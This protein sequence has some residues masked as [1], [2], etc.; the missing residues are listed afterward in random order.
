MVKISDVFIGTKQSRYAAFAIFSA[1]MAVCLFI[2]FTSTDVPFGQRFGIV[3]FLIIFSIPSVLMTLF[4]LTCIVTGGTSKKN[5]WCHYFAWIIALIII[6]YSIIIIIS[7]IMSLFTYNNAMDRVVESENAKRLTKEEAN[8]YA[9]NMMKHE[10]SQTP[11]NEQPTAQS[12]TQPM[13]QP[14][15]QPMSQHMSQP[16]AQPMSQPM[17]QPMT[18]SNIPPQNNMMTEKLS[19]YNGYE[20]TNNNASYLSGAYNNP[21]SQW[22]TI[23]GD[24]GLNKPIMANSDPNLAPSPYSM[25]DFS[26]F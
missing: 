1:I 25:N 7:V 21:M 18:Q 13:V 8:K 15:A 10:V 22:E 19:A 12:M 16:M 11:Q 9:E 3:L 2:L 4:E 17:A 23:N 14:T 26:S 24:N 5:A 6:V 20:P